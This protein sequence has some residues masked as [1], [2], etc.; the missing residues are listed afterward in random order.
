MVPWPQNSTGRANFCLGICWHEVSVMGRN[1]FFVVIVWC[2][3]GCFA[4][5]RWSE[6][7]IHISRWS[8][9]SDRGHVVTCTANF[10]T[11]GYCL[12][13]PDATCHVTRLSEII[14][15]ISV[16]PRWSQVVPDPDHS[17]RFPVGMCWFIYFCQLLIFDYWIRHRPSFRPFVHPKNNLDSF[18]RTLCVVMPIHVLAYFTKN[19]II[20][21]MRGTLELRVHWFF[22]Y[23]F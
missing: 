5:S 1:M 9:P 23:L 18:S 20:W 12:G 13:H 15:I 6:V 22:I 19:T 10:C 4:L 3:F 8:L 7:I 17:S 14:Q 16:D 11:P 21:S 2:M